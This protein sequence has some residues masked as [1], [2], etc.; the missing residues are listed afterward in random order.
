MKN[1]Y[2]GDIRDC[3]KYDLLIELV[4]GLH[5]EQL[6]SIPM[7]TPSDS[8]SRD[9]QLVN[10]P[11]NG[12]RQ[13]LV[14]FLK[15][16]VRLGDRDVVHLRNYFK[17]S[18]FHY[19]PYNDDEYFQHDLRGDYIA[20][21]PDRALSRALIFFD[22]DNGFEVASMRRG[23]GHKYLRFSELDRVLT[24]MGN[25]SIAVVY[26][27]LPR[28]PREEYFN[29][30]SSQFGSKLGQSRCTAV[31]DGQIAFFTFALD[32]SVHDQLHSVL[33]A[34]LNRVNQVG[35]RLSVIPL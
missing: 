13:D 9:G 27:H 7:L 22:P 4:Q 24:R 20:N 16:Q 5:L 19:T 34:Y 21:I 30:M 10:Y 17:K 1:Q 14:T 18:N 31:T 32:Q 6:T 23:N 8:E 11:A 3:F 35:A 2:F 15:E 25:Q 26:Q 28:K 12:R 29:H 33:L